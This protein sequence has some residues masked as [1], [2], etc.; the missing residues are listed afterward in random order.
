MAQMRDHACL[1]RLLIHPYTV[2]MCRLSRNLPT[3][4]YFSCISLA[5][6]GFICSTASA[7]AFHVGGSVSVNTF[8]SIAL[9]QLIGTSLSVVLMFASTS[10]GTRMRVPMFCQ[11]L[12]TGKRILSASARHTPAVVNNK[13]DTPLYGLMHYIFIAK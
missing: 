1:L 10:A 4:T 9:K 6:A 7:I 12:A 5:L 8:S 2:A 11:S 3:P 13:V